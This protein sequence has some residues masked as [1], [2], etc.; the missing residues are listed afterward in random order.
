MPLFQAVESQIRSFGQTPSQLLIEPHPPRGSAMQAVSAALARLLPA[1]LRPCLTSM[2]VFR[3]TCS[4]SAL[5][6]NLW[7]AGKHHMLSSSLWEGKCC[8]SALIVHQVML[9][10]AEPKGPSLSGSRPEGQSLQAWDGQVF[11]V[12][13]VTVWIS[14]PSVFIF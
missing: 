4:F 3:H 1:S 5:F 2:A 8:S 6:V 14:F 10:V 12:D 9:W 7:I 11:W 13:P